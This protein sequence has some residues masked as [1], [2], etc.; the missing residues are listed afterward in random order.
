MIKG[1]LFA[2]NCMMSSYSLRY[3]GY[4]SPAVLFFLFNCIC[5]TRGLSTSNINRSEILSA[6][7]GYRFNAV[8]LCLQRC[9]SHLFEDDV[10]V[11]GNELSYL[12][13]LSGLHRV[14]TIL[15]VS[16]VLKAEQRTTLHIQFNVL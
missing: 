1:Q 15:V 12:L 2:L 6:T 13:S 7:G 3:L 4:R 5:P 14:V 10:D 16:E 11:T 8:H 9:M